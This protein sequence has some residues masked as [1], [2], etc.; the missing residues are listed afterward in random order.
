MKIGFFCAFLTE[1]HYISTD[2]T[3]RELVAL[4]ILSECL[5]KGKLA[6]S[7]IYEEYQVSI[8]II[9]ALALA[10][11]LARHIQ[12]CDLELYVLHVAGDREC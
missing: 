8:P 5:A 9:A 6:L 11:A 4:K 10:L 2:Q 1:Y 7:Y 12:L 3:S